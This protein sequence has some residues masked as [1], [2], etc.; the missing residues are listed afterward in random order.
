MVPVICQVTRYTGHVTYQQFPLLRYQKSPM[1]LQNFSVGRPCSGLSS[2][3]SYP[4]TCCM[5]PDLAVH[6]FS[7]TCIPAPGDILDT[8]WM[9]CC[10]HPLGHGCKNHEGPGA[11][12]T[13]YTVIPRPT[14]IIRSG[15]TFVSRNFS[16]S[17]T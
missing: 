4:L 16:L 14:K 6:Y 7:T 12:A 13:G 11:R 1:R 15:I 3:R 9:F 5:P 10:G 2:S 17:R 8:F